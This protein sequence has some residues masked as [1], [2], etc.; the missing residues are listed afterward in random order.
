MM[1]DVKLRGTNLSDC[2]V[3][4]VSVWNADTDDRTKQNNL[5][6]SDVDDPVLTV[7]NL[8][9]VQFVYL[10]L[11]NVKIRDVIDTITSKVVLI[12]GRFTSERKAL[13]DAFR[14]ERRCRDYLPV[15]FDFQKPGSRGYTETVTTLARMA[16][17]IIADLTDATEV[18]VELAKIIPDLPSVPI[19]PLLLESKGEYVTF[20]DFKPYPWVLTPFLYKDTEHAIASLPKMILVPLEAKVKRKSG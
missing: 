6:V 9:V 8:E 11:N 2:K 19:K 7:D 1:V 4:G 10:I 20:E 5:I 12:L 17:F 13:L 18:R 16:R 15:M 14:D 3:F